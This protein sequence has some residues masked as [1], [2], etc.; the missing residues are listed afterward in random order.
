MVE[1]YEPTLSQMTSYWE[2]LNPSWQKF[3]AS[4]HL[5]NAL[6]KIDAVLSDILL[7]GEKDYI[8]TPFDWVGSY[9]KYKND[10]FEVRGFDWGAF[11]NGKKQPY[12]FKWDYLKVHWYKSL[13]YGDVTTNVPMSFFESNRMLKECLDSLKS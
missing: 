3:K 8:K 9:C 10:V 5:T 2:E 1:I 6:V 12:N 4:K 11:I 7:D 13:Y